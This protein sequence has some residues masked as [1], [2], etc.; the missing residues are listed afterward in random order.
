M[1]RLLN[2]ISGSRSIQPEEQVPFSPVS[3][4]P[5]PAVERG[6][7]LFATLP[8]TPPY[9]RGDHTPP[10]S[11]KRS[12][13]SDDIAASPDLLQTRVTAAAELRRG[14]TC[15]TLSHKEVFSPDDEN[16]A[17]TRAS[18]LSLHNASRRSSSSSV[19]STSRR[20]LSQLS[21][22]SSRTDSSA[23]MSQCSFPLGSKSKQSSLAAVHEP[24]KPFRLRSMTTDSPS[25]Q[26]SPRVPPQ[27]AHRP[28]V[29]T[30]SGANEVFSQ[31]D[32]L[33]AIR[34]ANELS[35]D[36][37]VSPR[38]GRTSTGRTSSKRNTRTP[39]SETIPESVENAT[40]SGSMPR[41]ARGLRHAITNGS[42][43]WPHL[44]LNEPSSPSADDVRRS[45]VAQSSCGQEPLSKELARFTSFHQNRI[46]S[47]PSAGDALLSQR[48][49]PSTS[50]SST[51]ALQ[52]QMSWLT[53]AMEVVSDQ[54][55]DDE[56][57]GAVPDNEG[58]SPRSR[59][60]SHWRILRNSQV[61]RSR[62]S[63]SATPCAGSDRGSTCSSV[64]MPICPFST[65]SQ[66]S[67]RHDSLIEPLVEESASFDQPLSTDYVSP[68]EKKSP[69]KI[70]PRFQVVEMV[71][72][73]VI[74]LS[75]E[76]Q[77]FTKELAV[78][79]A[80]RV[81]LRCEKHNSVHFVWPHSWQQWVLYLEREREQAI[82]ALLRRRDDRAATR[83]QT[84]W[85]TSE[86]GR[87]AAS[88][89]EQLKAAM[90]LQAVLRGFMVRL[91]HADDIADAWV[92]AH[93]QLEALAATQRVEALTPKPLSSPNATSPAALLAGS[94]THA[95]GNATAL[96]QDLIFDDNY[97]IDAADSFQGGR[98][99]A[100]NRATSST[101]TRRFSWLGQWH[102]SILEHGTRGSNAKPRFSILKRMGSARDLRYNINIGD[103]EGLPMSRGYR[104]LARKQHWRICPS[105]NGV[106]EHR[107]ADGNC[108][109]PRCGHTCRW[110]EAPLA[111]AVSSLAQ[112]RLEFKWQQLEDIYHGEELSW[113][114]VRQRYFGS[115]PLPECTFGAAIKLVC[116]RAL[117]SGPLFLCKPLV[118]RHA[119]TRYRKV[120]HDYVENAVV[121]A[122]DS[123]FTKN[124]KSGTRDQK[125][126]PNQLK[127]ISD[128]M[129]IDIPAAKLAT[130]K[131]VTAKLAAPG[132]EVKPLYGSVNGYHIPAIKTHSP[133][134]AHA[135]AYTGQRIKEDTY[136]S[137]TQENDR[138]AYVLHRL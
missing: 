2:K 59:G 52:S 80:L 64:A 45:G 13:S 35:G 32:E 102:P 44:R 6:A 91:K 61:W 67:A 137:I 88:A 22:F 71:Q 18:M 95:S 73:P 94:G 12:A 79:R 58:Q 103:D 75:A 49:S 8:V 29:A 109:C 11:R 70:Q 30:A 56:A 9:A 7:P 40:R 96:L 138:P 123:S 4:P 128:A 98:P 126:P 76:E 84:G 33:T 15:G 92:M 39:A 74:Y 53:H 136:E 130:A 127:K 111:V 5:S 113:P 69:R 78:R 17:L 114:F 110:M 129:K 14:N 50:K 57:P 68:V 23:T 120:Q 72:K 131:L 124:N 107:M 116:W 99:S 81:L 38:R 119:E 37:S 24:Q 36:E 3:I 108:F 105:C 121:S 10:R 25:S 51:L 66:S 60:L 20:L 21:W 28:R 90:L 77:A 43:K 41:S 118:L 27:A 62:S 46:S 125:D 83:L 82:Q 134:A 55:S 115:S 117:L 63:R 48:S 93:A 26:T 104:R 122:F 101:P 135:A 106:I 112:L 132:L 31:Q 16:S 47:T 54:E 19:I 89:R 100:R 34:H 42:Y 85:R 65:A 87:Q 1:P 133:R 86:R 97:P